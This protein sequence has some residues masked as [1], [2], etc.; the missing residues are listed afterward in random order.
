ME[1]NRQILTDSNA[2]RACQLPLWFLRPSTRVAK[3]EISKFG[4][5]HFEDIERIAVSCS[6]FRFCFSRCC[7]LRCSMMY[8]VRHLTLPIL[9]WQYCLCG[10]WEWSLTTVV[11]FRVNLE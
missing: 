4:K 10:F 2:S 3:F 7:S 1:H 6:C 11:G 5:R 8:R 9:I